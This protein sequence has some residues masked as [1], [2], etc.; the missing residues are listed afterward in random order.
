MN[1]HHTVQP[2]AKPEIN[3]PMS[4][5]F[6]SHSSK[7]KSWV[8]VLAKRLTADGV[9]VWLDEAE[10]NIGDSLIEKISI[11]IEEMEYVIAVISKNSINSNWVQK[12]LNLAMTKEINGRR[13]TVLPLLIQQCE[14]PKALRDKLYADFTQPDK[15]ELEY[16]KLLRS[17]KGKDFEKI[18]KKPA[19]KSSVTANKN[20]VTK[21]TS[22]N[23]EVKI[24]GVV[25]ERIHQDQEYSGLYHV[26][27]QL[28]PRPPAGWSN[29]FLEAR[30][31]PRHTMW[32]EA[33]VEGDC[34]VV[35][36]ALDELE[37]YHIRD[38]NEDVITANREFKSAIIRAEHAR[39]FLR[40]QEAEQRCK[41]D[42]ILDKIRFD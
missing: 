1:R 9:V 31:F 35:K 18:P 25:K 40:K 41:R 36:C 20:E 11:A 27:L 8:R 21:D 2:V 16:S 4:S 23:D 28:S 34:I 39:E 5:V 29:Y 38:V 32:R 17:L 33:W 26:Y 12:E 15:Y 42:E 19:I 30:R 24:V 3:V 6:L 37:K 14:L 10:L 22:Q 7:D 13:V